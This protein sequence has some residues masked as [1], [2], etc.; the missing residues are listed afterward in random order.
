LGHV[1]ADRLNA[2]CQVS[3]PDANLG[4]AEPEAE[5]A[6][7]IGQPGHQVPDTRIDAG[8]LHPDQ[9]IVLADHRQLDLP[10]LQYIG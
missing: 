3:A 1:A 4:R 8:R 7:Q 9:H 5:D 6:N 10:E 2:A